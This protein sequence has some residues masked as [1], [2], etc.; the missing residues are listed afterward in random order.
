[1]AGTKAKT[2]T[3]T[4]LERIAKL[5]GENPCMEFIGLMPH[6]NRE[7]LIGCFNELDGRKAVGIDQ[8]T[9]EEYG[10]NLGANVDDLLRRMKG[11]RYRPSPVKEV[12]IPKVNGKTRPL[13]ISTL[14]DKMVQLMFSKILEA[15]YEPLFYDF[16]F[17][18]RKGISAHDAIKACLQHLHKGRTNIVLDIDLENF[19]GTICHKKLIALLRMKIKDERFIRYIVRMLKSGVLSEG[20][21]RKTDE[22]TPQGSCCSPILA[23]IYA[24]YAIDQWFNEVVR[25]RVG[26]EVGLYRY[27]DDFVICCEREEDAER[28]IQAIKGRMERFALKLNQEK[29]RKVNFSKSKKQN[30]EKQGTFD[31]LG[32]T[33]YWGKSRKGH[34]ISKVKTSKKRKRSK[35]KVVKDWCRRNRHKAKLLELWKIF[36]SKLRG[37]IQYYG[38]SFNSQEVRNFVYRA[39]GLFYKWMNRRSQKRS[40]SWDSFGRFLKIYPPPKPI[41]HHRMF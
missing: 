25:A 1:M 15:I 29:T 35:L 21:M 10:K 36:C 27:C 39:V 31:F 19:F 16:S 38:V 13:G 17:G 18:F 2:M 41:V 9:K 5:S 20:E 30:G 23:N 34:W 33:F 22:G 32:F 3:A 26:G 7:S 6:V 40:F 37:H 12:L 24:H 14:E 8:V 4:K 11:M 28:I